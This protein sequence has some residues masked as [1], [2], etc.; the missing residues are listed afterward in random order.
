MEELVLLGVRPS[1]DNDDECSMAMHR[2]W[3]DECAKKMQN[4][5]IYYAYYVN[6]SFSRRGKRKTWS[7]SPYFL[8]WKLPFPCITRIIAR[9]TRTA[10]HHWLFVL[11]KIIIISYCMISWRCELW[12]VCRTERWKWGSLKN[13]ILISNAPCLRRILVDDN[14]AKDAR[15][16]IASTHPP[17]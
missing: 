9:G 14:A 3:M 7:E 15:W 12:C 8:D 1:Y 2:Q 6:W 13:C 4:N 16:R 10:H 5:T 11:I 17:T